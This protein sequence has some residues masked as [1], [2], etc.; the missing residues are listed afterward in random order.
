MLGSPGMKG[1][2]VPSPFSP[3][4]P[5]FPQP[6]EA[7]DVL[8]EQLRREAAEGRP[9]GAGEP[10]F[11]FLGCRV[12][13][14][15]QILQAAQAAKLGGSSAASKCWCAVGSGIRKPSADGNREPLPGPWRPE[16]RAVGTEVKR[17]TPIWGPSPHTFAGGWVSS[18][19]KR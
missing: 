12:P 3:R 1:V 17:C 16:E 19:G 18:G 9:R 4:S 14:R 13:G 11:W 6:K 10:G 7:G 8:E 2:P 5:H 15:C